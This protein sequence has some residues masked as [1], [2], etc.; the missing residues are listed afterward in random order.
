M[1]K[2]AIYQHFNGN[3]YPFYAKYLVGTIK[4]NGDEQCTALCPLHDD[5]SPSFSFNT[6]TGKYFCHG[7]KKGGDVFR[8][9]ADLKGLDQHRDFSQILEGIARDFGIS[10]NK[11]DPGLKLKIVKAY[12]YRDI[13]GKMLFQVCRCEPKTFRQRRPDPDNRDR[14]I[15]KLDDVK[16]VLYHLPKVL[17]ALEIII[18]EGEKDV[19]NVCELGFTATTSPMGAKKWIPEYSEYL[20]GKD[21]VL[22]PDNDDEGREH[23]RQVAASLHGIAGT[24]KWLDLPDLPVKGDISDWIAT[25]STKEEATERLT[26]MIDGAS[27]YEPL[28][29][30]EVEEPYPQEHNAEPQIEQSR[31]PPFPDI[32]S[33]AAGEFATV[34]GEALEPPKQFF[35]MSYLTCLGNALSGRL[36]VKSELSVEP[37]LYT[38]I[39]GESADD[40]KSTAISKTVDFF[41]DAITEFPVCHGLGSAEGLTT[42]LNKQSGEDKSVLLVFDEFK[43]FVSKSRID[44]SILLPCLTSLFEATQFESHTKTHSINFNKTHLSLLAASTIDTYERISDTSFTAIGFPNRLFLVA[45]TGR[46]KHAFPER[47]DSTDRQQLKRRLGEILSHVG[48]TLELDIEDEARRLY[49][50][51]YM[52]LP[53]SIHA[54]RLDTYAMRLMML[55]AVNDQKT[56]IDTETVHKVM[57]LCDWQYEIRHI[58]DPVDADSVVAKTEQKI[59]RCLEASPKNDRDLKRY[60]HAHRIGLWVY[61]AALKNLQTAKEIIWNN[62][63]KTWVLG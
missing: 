52:A 19:D 6:K 20:R 7:C 55:L 41:C 51:W 15:W 48:S 16:R 9:Y 56:I 24:I 2:T 46:R 47:I 38:L 28:S 32:L 27:F 29:V 3:Y 10:D 44:G 49:T 12:T 58:L 40:R 22:I 8:F 18:V 57:A 14:W 63:Q 30:C 60:V 5:R 59:R 62:G 61:Q 31:I 13:D 37:R 42:A 53:Q 54:K 1:E 21:V 43:T 4:R 11:N 50:E 36:I 33:G 39:L 34:Y 17:K 35:F 25:V 23:M 45:G 26:L